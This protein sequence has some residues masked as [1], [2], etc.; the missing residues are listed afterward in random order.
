MGQGQGVSLIS[1]SR[2]WWFLGRAQ[3]RG[4]ARAVVTSASSRNDVTRE[5]GHSALPNPRLLQDMFPF[6]K[7]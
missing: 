2:E 4:R 7:K 1:G 5:L 6:L 3:W